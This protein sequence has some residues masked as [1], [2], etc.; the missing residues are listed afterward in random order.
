MNSMQDQDDFQF[1]PLTDGLG[2]HKKPSQTIK[3]KVENKS[4][5]DRD[6]SML[7][8]LSAPLPR[9]GE[10]AKAII[11]EINKENTVDEILKTLNQRKQQDFIET[12]KTAPVQTQIYKPTRIDFS[13]ALLDGLLIFAGSLF[14]LIVLL[15][16]T[17]VDL[18]A[19]LYRPDSQGLIYLSLL[20][21]ICG[22]AWIYMVAHRLY[23]GFTPGEWVFDQRLGKP[24]QLGSASYSLKAAARTTFV[25]ATGFILFP[26]LSLMMNKDVLGKI[27]GLEMFKKQMN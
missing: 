19:N 25:M 3:P 2:F 1:K 4:F 27:T 17:K 11:P 10:I 18:F 6:L 16:V 7:T 13:A 23:L 8:D 12:Q 15:L 14:C 21:L 20:T 26:V 24:E 5:I 9:K 22:V